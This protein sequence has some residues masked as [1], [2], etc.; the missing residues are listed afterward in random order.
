MHKLKQFQIHLDPRLKEQLNRGLLRLAVLVILF[1]KKITDYLYFMY[2]IEP[3]EL[4]MDLYRFAF[5]LAFFAL[6]NGGAKLITNIEYRITLYLL[7]NNFYDRYHGITEWST[8]DT[9]TVILIGIEALIATI[10]KS[11][12]P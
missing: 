1:V 2:D 3:W 12:I 5:M 6:G 9:I 10:K 7:I 4:G 11:K 8:N